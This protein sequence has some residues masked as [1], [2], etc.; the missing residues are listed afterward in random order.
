MLI[1]LHQTLHHKLSVRYLVSALV[2]GRVKK[3]ALPDHNVTHLKCL[4]TV[5]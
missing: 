2:T 5:P 4:V 3:W 1:T